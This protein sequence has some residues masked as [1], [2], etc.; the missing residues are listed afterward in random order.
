MSTLNLSD[1]A[2]REIVHK[3]IF[4]AISTEQRDALIQAALAHLM[5]PEKR[6]GDSFGRGTSPL[7]AAFNHAVERYVREAIHARIEKDP[8]WQKGLDALI[9]ETMTTFLS[10]RRTNVAT[11]LADAMA[12]ALLGRDY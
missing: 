12:R 1:E 4:D 3:A 6:A 11:K 10:E 7:Q 8:E 5:M 2:L 9:A